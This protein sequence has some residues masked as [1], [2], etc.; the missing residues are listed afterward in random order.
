MS[1]FEGILTG[2]ATSIDTQLKKDME[3]TQERAEG[4]AQYRVTRRRAEIERQDKE[5]REVSDVLN[6]LAGLVGGD[7]DKAAQLYVSG[8]KSVS[9]G[10]ALYD[11]LKKN[12]DAGKDI[13][14]AITFAEARAKPGQMT[15]YVSQFITPISE[16]PPIKGE[17]KGAG[18]YGAMFKPDLAKSVMAQVDEEAPLTAAQKFQ[19]GA[20]PSA[21]AIDRTGFLAAEEY[22]ETVAQRGRAAAGEA[23]AVAGE[24]RNV[25][26]FDTNQKSLKQ[27]MEIQRD[28]ETRAKDKFASDADQRKLENARQEVIDLQTQA[29]LIQDAEAQVKQ[30]KKDDLVIQKTEMEIAQDKAHPIFKNYEDMAVYAS[31]ALATGDY[32]EGYTEDDYTTLLNNAI[33]GAKKYANATEADD[34]SAGDIEFSKQSL[35]SIIQGAM[36]NELDMVPSESIEGKIKYAIDGNEVDYYSGVG[37]ALQIVEKRLTGPSTK[38]VNQETGE[39]ETVPGTMSREAKSYIDG[40][41][42]SNTQKLF[43][44]ATKM[45]TDYA[46]A[47]VNKRNKIKFVPYATVSQVPP[48][49]IKKYAR[50]N[51]IPAGSVVEMSD[52]GKE[53]GIWTGSRFIK[54]VDMK[55]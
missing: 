47:N 44:F 33:T 49:G 27:A 4:M 36:K 7:V 37:R 48:L 20:G 34:P 12:A 22:G 40:L 2:A 3:R 17:I 6:K 32:K 5:K 8:G 21:A 16:L 31:Q 28:A 38:R 35:D 26:A 45:K 51:N 13:S 46:N 18:L 43:N 15:D 30:M 23:R 29:K 54:A 11:E 14:T 19:E 1:F 53:Y 52:D 9:G 10:T 50:D 39:E 41:K 42:A 24:A 25:T 55:L